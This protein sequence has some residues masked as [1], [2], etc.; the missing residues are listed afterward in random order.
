M[1]LELWDLFEKTDTAFTKR[2][3]TGAKL[4][5]INPEYQIKKF[6]EHFGPCGV[7]WG[8]ELVSSE[9][10]EGAAMVSRKIEGNDGVPINF[11][12]CL[13]HTAKVKLWFKMPEDPAVHKGAEIHS[14]TATG[15]TKFVY[16]TQYGPTTDDEYEKK[17]TTDA[18]TKAMSFLGMG[19]D[20]RMGMF[21]DPEYVAQLQ[22]DEAIDG[23]VDREAAL[24]EQRQEYDDW[25]D[26]TLELCRTAT[27]MHELEVIFK[28]SLVRIA[29]QGT[30][31][32]TNKLTDSK[33]AR[34]TE[35][36]R[37]E[38]IAKEQRDKEEQEQQT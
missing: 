3:D 36:I 15:H 35:L 10:I 14:I 22:L 11:G 32:Q 20:I 21:D 24:I 19:G 16:M 12:P 13:I 17:S 28:S 33:N 25:Y 29:G 9:M 1:S 27:S 7:G 31:D 18:L 30:K 4:T 6:T 38:R 34:A 8:F 2:Q 37:A 23:S 26:K 5:S